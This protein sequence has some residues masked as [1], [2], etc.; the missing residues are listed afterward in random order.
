MISVV[1]PLYNKE[2]VIAHTLKTVINQQFKDFEVVIVNDGSTDDGVS[3]IKNGFDDSRIR[4][5]NQENQGVAVAR[6]RG[7]REA[8]YQYIAFLDADDEWHPEYLKIMAETI[9]MY[10]GAGLFSSAGLIIDSNG[11]HYRLA[12]KYQNYIG[13]VDWM[14]APFVFTHTSGTIINRLVFNCTKGSPV[15]MRCLQDFALFMQIALRSDVV[16]VGL[17]IS[18]YVGGVPGQTTSA[19]PEKRY[20]LLEYV[21]YFYSMAYKDWVGL[22]KKNK[23]FLTYHKYIVRNVC[24]NLIKVDERSIIYF[25]DHLSAEAKQPFFNF[26]WRLYKSKYKKIAIFWINITKAL[27]HLYGYPVGGEKVDIN[28][29]P[30]KYRTW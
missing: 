3:V 11:C 15:G 13:K 14:E 8:K 22:G 4:I 18:K 2:T 29:I 21:C 26:E 16:Y 10:P 1:I 20:R 17:P 19:D 28:M 24:K 30:S 6:D 27:W 25:I 7:V 5:I 12:R 23:K 9:S